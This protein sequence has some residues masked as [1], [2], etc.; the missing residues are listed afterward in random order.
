MIGLPRGVCVQLPPNDP[1]RRPLVGVPDS[2]SAQWHPYNRPKTRRRRR[3][4]DASLARRNALVE[5]FLTLL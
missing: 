3:A 5:Q 4:S 2:A 1:T